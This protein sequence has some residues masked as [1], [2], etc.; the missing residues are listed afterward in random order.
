MGLSKTGKQPHDD[1]VSR[2]E[3]TRQGATAAA[4]TAGGAG[5][6]QSVV[7]ADVAFYRAARDSAIANDMPLSGIM[8]ALKALGVNT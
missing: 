7:N 4:I 5:V 6:Q 3:S 8:S 2:S 1:A